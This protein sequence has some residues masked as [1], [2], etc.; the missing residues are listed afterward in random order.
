ML[1][2]V[3]MWC[4]WLSACFER[5]CVPVS[6]LVGEGVCVCGNMYA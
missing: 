2:C 5:T 1:V 4:V 3:H 6:A